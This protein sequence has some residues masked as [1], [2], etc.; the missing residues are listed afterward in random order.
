ML[1]PGSG[2]PSSDDVNR[3]EIVRSW[4]DNELQANRIITV[5]KTLIG[6]AV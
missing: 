5:V 3:P 1:I 6:V 4:A 2:V